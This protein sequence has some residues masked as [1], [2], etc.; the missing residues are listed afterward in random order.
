[1]FHYNYFISNTYMSF[2]KIKCKKCAGI[3]LIL[4]K[5]KD[6]QCLQCNE[7]NNFCMYCENK[8]FRGNYT[9][10]VSCLGLGEILVCTETKNKVDI[11]DHM[12]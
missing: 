9:E 6:K 8:K 3:G 2:Y 1:M 12:N 7:K 11:S 4:K 10:C 5:E